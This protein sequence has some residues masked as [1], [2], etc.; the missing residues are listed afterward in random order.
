MTSSLVLGPGPKPL[1]GKKKKSSCVARERRTQINQTLCEL[2]ALLCPDQD[3]LDK[4]TV[5]RLAAATIKLHAFLKGVDQNRPCQRLQH[6]RPS[7]TRRFAKIL[8]GFVIILSASG[9]VLYVSDSIKD[10]LEHSPH[11]IVGEYI[12]SLV[13]PDDH[14]EINRNLVKETSPVPE[15]SFNSSSRKRKCTRESKSSSTIYHKSDKTMGGPISDSSDIDIEMGGTPHLPIGY[16]DLNSP[17]SNASL[18]VLHPLSKTLKRRF[19]C[20]MKCLQQRKFKR[21]VKNWG[22]KTVYCS[23]YQMYD[24]KE[25]GSLTCKGFIGHVR[26]LQPP[27]IFEIPLVD[28]SFMTHHSL[29]MNYIFTDKRLQAALGYLP[30][31]VLGQS[32]YNFVHNDDLERLSKFHKNLLDKGE[33]I[34]GYYRLAAH[35]NAGWVTIQ[36]QANIIYNK[37]EH[38]TADYIVSINYIIGQ[39]SPQMESSQ[40]DRASSDTFT[41][42]NV[43]VE[44][45]PR[46]VQISELLENGLFYTNTGEKAVPSQITRHTSQRRVEPS[47]GFYSTSLLQPARDPTTRDPHHYPS[48][49]ATP[50]VLYN[51]ATFAREMELS[52]H[53]VT[54]VQRDVVQPVRVPIVR[55]LT[56]LSRDVTQIPRQRVQH[57]I[58][59]FIN[60]S[61][62]GPNTI[63]YFPTSL[64]P[65]EL[66]DQR[67]SMRLGAPTT[68][69]PECQTSSFTPPNIYPHQTSTLHHVTRQ[70]QLHTTPSATPYIEHLHVGNYLRY[71][72]DDHV[73]Y[74]ANRV[75]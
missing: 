50:Q 55:D 63:P 27:A 54:H 34:S 52:S 4:L 38:V 22:Y 41:R 57:D 23:G 72:E 19:F 66:L 39:T 35:N 60:T 69:Y 65:S 47:S 14:E 26:P 44:T 51:P 36:S 9:Q 45:V 43:V 58:T 61:Y 46:P 13:H 11:N 75:S 2:G 29:D 53:N 17:D 20:R 33:C 24:I 32:I 8:D 70:P 6:Q 1:P 12:H 16:D 74:D 3:R 73:Y 59:E 31:E 42:S 37:K 28:G 7:L 64:P 40:L 30:E 48:Y 10:S 71:L 67:Y 18:R 49:V 68:L 15:S 56:H 5:V 21:L 25:S 62:H